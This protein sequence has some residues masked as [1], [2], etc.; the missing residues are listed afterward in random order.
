MERSSADVV[1]KDKTIT[2]HE[3]PRRPTK[4]AQ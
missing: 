2:F 4:C 3:V 1:Q